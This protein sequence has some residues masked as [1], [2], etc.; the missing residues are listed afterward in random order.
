M[1]VRGTFQRANE[2]NTNKRIYP[3][4]ILETQ[5]TNLQ[6]MVADR[7]LLGELDHPSS[8]TVSL[9]NVSHLI[10][11]LQM[12]GDEVIGE[13]ELLNTPAGMTAQALIKGGVQVGISSRGMGTLSEGDDDTKIVNEDFKLVTFDLVADPSTRGAYP[14][15]AESVQTEMREGAQCVK[16]CM[17]KIVSERIFVTALKNKL[18][19]GSAGVEGLK[20][21]ARYYDK[22]WERAQKTRYDST[23]GDAEDY[24]RER[25]DLARRR[26][27][28]ARKKSL[29]THR[30]I[31][32]R[33]MQGTLRRG[34]RTAS[35]HPVY[36]S[37]AKL[38][39]DSTLWPTDNISGFDAE[40]QRAVTPATKERMK[41]AAKARK[42]AGKKPTDTRGI[43]VV[44]AGRPPAK[45]K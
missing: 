34:S 19:E 10:T 6:P 43:N 45:R 11:N 8:D 1:R 13:A 44:V 30:R 26:T 35:N 20:R 18:N 37:M 7:R 27:A 36:S 9:S 32:H 25:Q 5:V 2:A 22:E 24:T 42:K 14:A 3:K 39:A 28:A 41:A 33:K 40:R 4:A 21:K 23:P 15:L 17:E 12:E 29:E 31:G 38:V 16:D